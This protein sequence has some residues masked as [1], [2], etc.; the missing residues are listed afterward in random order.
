MIP[1]CILIHHSLTADSGTVSWGAIRKFHMTNPAYM[2]RDIGYHWG[3]ELIGDHYECLAGRMMNEVGAHCKEE[4][5]NRVSLGI[6]LVGNFDIAPPPKAQWD[7]AV[8]LTASLCG[9]LHIPTAM[10]F[11]HS[12][13]SPKTCPGTKFDMD[14]FKLAVS[15]RLSI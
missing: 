10:I 8:R 2:M 13:F 3:L 14:L 9:L 12:R 11:P 4:G 6:C 7:L 1:S 15:N 5:M